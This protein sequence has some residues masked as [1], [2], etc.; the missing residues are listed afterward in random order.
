[1]IVVGGANGTGKTTFAA[2]Y[3][4][5]HDCLYLA[6][7]AIADELSP[8]SPTSAAIRAGEE[9]MRRLAVAL[10]RSDSLVVEST[11]AGRTLQ[12]T[13]RKARL[14]GFVITVVYLFLDCEEACV[15]RVRERVQKGGHSVPEVDIRRRFWRS[16]VNFWTL[17]RPLA[18]HWLLVYNSSRHPLDVAVGAPGEISVRDA[19]LFTLFE[20]LIGD[21]THG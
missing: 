8:K 15:E 13:I 14:A 21:D 18:D 12:H 10:E 5:R 2:E 1:M 20:R 6:A 9:F 19:D 11:L 4:R 17:Y 7:D 3:S 16:L